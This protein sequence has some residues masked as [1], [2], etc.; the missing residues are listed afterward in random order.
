MRF[1]TFHLIGSP[2][3]APA[4]DRFDETLSHINLADQLG[5]DM[6]WVA[7]HHFS[8]YGYSANPLLLIARAAAT[9]PRVRFGQA[10]LVSPF[11]HPIRLAEDIATTDLLTGGRLDIG[12]GR[13][14]QPLEFHGFAIAQDESRSMFAEHVELM[15]LAW[16]QDDFT[17]S[18]QHY[19]VPT[20]I[21]VLPRPL[22]QPHPPI[23]LAVQ[24]ETSLKWAAANG[25]N[26]LLTGGG[27]EWDVLGRWIDTHR[28]AA[29]SQA[30]IGVLRHVLV[31]ER[32]ADARAALWQ[33]RWQRNVAT[34]LRLGKERVRGG[35]ND[36]TGYVDE[37]TEEAW[38]DRVVYGTPE[39]CIAQLRRQADQGVTD[40][41]AWFDIGGLPAAQVQTSMQLFAHEVMP[42]LATTVAH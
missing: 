35:R 14:D 16:T 18:G 9:A 12:L 4:R 17:F 33:S 27:T 5:F 32:E 38:W 40:F 20:P 7:E 15:R 28:N 22:Q 37:T 21:T 2:E 11:W 34:Q 39:R 36:L 24:S 8:N 42:A 1:G 29:G 41:L 19:Q 25:C 23:W 13:G 31:T 6:V 26:V 30:R 10:V 3:M